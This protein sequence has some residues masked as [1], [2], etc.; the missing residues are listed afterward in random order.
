MRESNA[1]KRKTHHLF[2]SRGSVY[3]HRP[4]SDLV[5]A[6]IEEKTACTRPENYTT[7][8][9]AHHIHS[10]KA[11]QAANKLSN[12]ISLPVEL[13]KHSP[14]FT[15]AITLSAIVHLSASSIPMYS[16]KSAVMRERVL[17]ATGALKSL[18]VIWAVA[19]SVLQQVKE[20][21]RGVLAFDPNN[22][23]TAVFA[24]EVNNGASID[25]DHHFLQDAMA[26]QLPEEGIFDLI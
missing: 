10:T 7:P 4:R 26:T 21:A 2:S 23:S 25:V 5:F 12:L 1:H 8:I 9:T 11:I 14:F 15:C 3:L 16:D 22:L 6:P 19:G 24:E 20:V 13:T 18:S 17:L